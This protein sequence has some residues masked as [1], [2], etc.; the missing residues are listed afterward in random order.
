MQ[1]LTFHL[2]ELTVSEIARLWE[3]SDGLAAGRHRHQSVDAYLTRLARILTA[4][5]KWRSLGGLLAA[6]ALYTMM[7][8]SSLVTPPST[9][10]FSFE[11]L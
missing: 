1:S 3:G 9:S 6:L 4:N 7:L 5:K 8:L 2:P 11:Q 10:H